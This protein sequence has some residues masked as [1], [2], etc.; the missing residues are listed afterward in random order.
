[1]I[2]R[3]TLR[4]GK[5]D[6]PQ[7]ILTEFLDDDDRSFEHLM[8]TVLFGADIYADGA[9]PYV[10]LVKEIFDIHVDILYA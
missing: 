7:R 5:R 1:M 6:N 10:P 3:H 2:E 4:T 9:P 8:F